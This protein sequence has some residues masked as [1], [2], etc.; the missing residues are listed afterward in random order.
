MQSYEEKFSR[1]VADMEPEDRDKIVILAEKIDDLT[2]VSQFISANKLTHRQH[3]CLNS[4]ARME[5]EL[6]ELQ[7]RQGQQARSLGIIFDIQRHLGDL[8]TALA[9]DKFEKLPEKINQL[10]STLSLSI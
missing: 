7:Q 2:F 3:A 8:N 1:T 5:T 9:Q 10:R 6:R 4:I